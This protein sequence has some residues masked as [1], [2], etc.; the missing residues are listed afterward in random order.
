MNSSKLMRE[1]IRR[2]EILVKELGYDVEPEEIAEDGYGASIFSQDDY[3]FGLTV[4]SQSKYLEI[5]YTFGFSR[6]LQE[7]IRRSIE[8][9]MGI[10]Y[11]YGCYFTLGMDDEEIVLS[12][13]SKLYFAG[14]N[15]YAFKETVRDLRSCITMIAELF[16][17]AGQLQGENEYGNP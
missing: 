12:V 8:E 16:D 11:E 6:S 3:L 17:F 9:V 2:V 7:R 5:G 1:R 13:F 10:T 15:Y 4:D 14:L